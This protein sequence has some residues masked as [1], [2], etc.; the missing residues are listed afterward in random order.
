MFSLFFTPNHNEFV[1]MNRSYF[2]FERVQ[3]RYEGYQDWAISYT[4]PGQTV[5]VRRRV[6]PHIGG[7]DLELDPDNLYIIAI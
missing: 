2:D 3:C 1:T 5:W 4:E 6:C 7:K